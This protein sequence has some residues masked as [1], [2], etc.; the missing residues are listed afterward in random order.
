MKRLLMFV[1]E[2]IQVGSAIICAHNTMLLTFVKS[3]GMLS[4][5]KQDRKVSSLHTPCVI[6]EVF[7]G[8]NSNGMVLCLRL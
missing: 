5:G 8:G 1:S 4:L 3:L 2:L 6:K 7:G